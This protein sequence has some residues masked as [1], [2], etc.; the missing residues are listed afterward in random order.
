M[1]EEKKETDKVNGK[2]LDLAGDG[3]VFDP[4]VL[5]LNLR[6][7]LDKVKIRTLSRE[8]TKFYIIDTFLKNHP[9]LDPVAESLRA[10]CIDKPTLLIPSSRLKLSN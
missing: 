8:D 2:S 1:T 9:Q 4:V 7:L 5:T 3:N 10:S 6:L